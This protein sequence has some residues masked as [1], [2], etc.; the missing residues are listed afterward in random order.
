MLFLH[1]IQKW[2]ITKINVSLPNIKSKQCE[3]SLEQD[4][5]QTGCNNSYFKQKKKLSCDVFTSDIVICNTSNS[6]YSNSPEQSK[7]HTEDERKNSRSLHS[8]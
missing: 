5:Q 1:I 4:T 3:T 7:R 8:Y 2:L 6:F